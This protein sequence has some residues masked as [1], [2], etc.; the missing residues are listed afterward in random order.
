MAGERPVCAL[1]TL[2][3]ELYVATCGSLV[4]DVFDVVTFR[5]GRR[6]T[7]P[8]VHRSL[9]LDVVSSG[10]SYVTDMTS[11]R[12]HRCLYAADGC[13]GVVRR[14]DAASGRQVTE[15]TVEGGARPAGLSV[16]GAFNVVVAC[17]DSVLVR[18]YTPLGCPVCVVDVH[19]PALVGLT[20]AVQL[21][22]GSFAVIGVTETTDRVA[23]VCRANDDADS[24]QLIDS[25]GGGF[26]TH[27][28]SVRCTAGSHVWLAERGGTSP[29]VRLVQ[30]PAASQRSA[31]LPTV[32]VRQPDK[33][34]WDQSARR[35]YVVDDGHVK[36]FRIRM[37][38]DSCSD[39]AFM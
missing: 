2:D 13:A 18:V 25:R 4:V 29:G 14:L 24:A 20:H 19:R 17:S 10:F 27:V 36:V 39:I 30:V 35:L 8:G 22:C 34:C 11:C 23:C 15:W 32:P 5:L 26:A 31:D 28:A 21:D 3:D 12:R 7:V 37:K 38:R 33:I 6:L 9:L 16:T 1:T